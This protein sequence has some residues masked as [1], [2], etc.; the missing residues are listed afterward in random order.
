MTNGQPN[1]HYLL[2]F[3]ALQFAWISSV[4]DILPF[5]SFSS[6]IHWQIHSALWPHGLL[7][8]LTNLAGPVRVLT[9]FTHAYFCCYVPLTP[10]C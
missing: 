2:L 1:L 9:H 10:T 6:V 7:A 8:P 3:S 4:T 5:Y